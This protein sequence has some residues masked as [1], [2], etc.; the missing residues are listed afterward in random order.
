MLLEAE[1]DRKVVVSSLLSKGIIEDEEM[2]NDVAV[3]A[4]V[5]K[6]FSAKWCY[7]ISTP[8]QVRFQPVFSILWLI[9][10]IPVTDVFICVYIRLSCTLFLQIE[11]LISAFD[12]SEYL[13][14]SLPF[15]LQLVMVIPATK[16][17]REIFS[18]SILVVSSSCVVVSLDQLCI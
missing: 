18:I 8:L 9:V 10:P 6:L 7:M 15:L 12:G 11:M 4:N 2:E 13:N 14:R 3:N 16:V 5:E 1:D 17:S